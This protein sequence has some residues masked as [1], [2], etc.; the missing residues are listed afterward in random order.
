MLV[1]IPALNEEATIAD[2]VSRV[3]RSAPGVDAVDVLV[4]N[5]GSTD[6]TVRCAVEAGADVVS[7]PQ[8]RGVGAAFHTAL[9]YAMARPVDLLVTIDGDG[10]FDP[11]DIPKLIR[12]VVE[13]RA[14]FTTASRFA[15]TT[16]TPSMP[17][18]KRWGN[19]M[20][21]RLIS[22]IAR[23]RFHDV[24]C[25]MRCY[26]RPAAMHLNLLGT[27]TYTQEVFLNLAFK[28]L[29]IVEVP[30]AVRGVRQH[31]DSRVAGSILRYALK[32]SSII[33][34]C[35]RDY[36]PMRFFGRLALALMV[37]GVGLAVYFLVNYIATGKFA[38]EKWAAFTGAAL[39]VFGLILL[40]MGVAGD[41][42]NRHRIYLEEL[43][44]DVRTQ[45]RTRPP[46][47]RDDGGVT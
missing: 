42:L 24:S 43:L 30:I 14:D 22:R 23:Q 26:N 44:Y 38:G 46:D 29:R 47:G 17:W 10:Q 28:G 16:L 18:V 41:M 45:R 3:P 35:Y 40:L 19:R 21:S 34:R 31:G 12:P 9:N 2:V 5:D 13:D 15:D 4:V 39:F 6:G 8:S 37:P 32:T 25:G 20:M 7:H 33:F 36:R 11:G 27:F 1:A